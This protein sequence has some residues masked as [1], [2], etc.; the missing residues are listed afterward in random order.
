CSRRP[1]PEV[2]EAADDDHV[3]DVVKKNEIVLVL[4]ERRNGVHPRQHD[5]NVKKD[6]PDEQQCKVQIAE[7][8]AQLA[9]LEMRA[10]RQRR[11]HGN[12]AE[13][14]DNVDWVV[15]GHVAVQIEFVVGPLELPDQP[16]RAAHGEEHPEEI[17]APMRSSGV[18]QKAGVS[19]ERHNAL[20]Q[21]SEGGKSMASPVQK[22]REAGIHDKKEQPNTGHADNCFGRRHRIRSIY[23]RR[24]KR[25]GLRRIRSPIRKYKRTPL[26]SSMVRSPNLREAGGGG[27]IRTPETLSGLTV[28]KTAGFNRSPTPPSLIVPGNSVWRDFL[29]SLTILRSSF[30]R[31]CDAKINSLHS[32]TSRSY[33][34]HTEGQRWNTVA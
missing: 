17:S 9:A 15:I 3:L 25:G 7:A 34:A 32:E 33:K 1:Q 27:G 31:C 18:H 16:E 14:E 28:F 22:Q 19:E 8:K 2:G 4:R 30:P 11:H 23:F 5:E 6:P 12:A 21:I 20:R 13:E 10:Q 26:S 24:A 29:V